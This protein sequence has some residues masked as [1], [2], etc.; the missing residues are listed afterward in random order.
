MLPQGTKAD[1]KNGS[2]PVFERARS[3]SKSPGSLTGVQVQAHSRHSA[4]AG[5]HSLPRQPS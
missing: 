3:Q 1:R 5:V 2:C 4:L